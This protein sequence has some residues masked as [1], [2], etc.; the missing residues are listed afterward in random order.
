VTK[1]GNAISAKGD[2]GSGSIAISTSGRYVRLTGK[3]P[4]GW[5]GVGY[6]FTLPPA[7]VY[8]SIWF[9]V[10]ARGELSTPEKRIGVQNFARCPYS[11]AAWSESCFDHWKGVGTQPLATVWH[12]AS[13]NVTV[14][15]HS[16]T[17]RGIV[18]VPYSTHT[19]YKARVKV[20]YSV[21]Q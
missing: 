14:N 13:A 19:I 7:T 6:L 9:Q 8:K 10:Y 17:V 1:Y 21:L 15:R 5:V 16:R 4:S 11:S 3:Y 20:V 2:P 12:S 18:S